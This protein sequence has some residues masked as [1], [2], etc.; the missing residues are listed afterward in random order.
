M[1]KKKGK[2]S[3]Y[4]LMAPNMKGIFIRT[5]FMEQ[6]LIHGLMEGNTLEVG[7]I[8]KCMEKGNLNG[9]MGENIM[10]II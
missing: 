7:K 2:E 10:G 5:A 3:S 4:G 8:I 9:Q 6:A 1:E